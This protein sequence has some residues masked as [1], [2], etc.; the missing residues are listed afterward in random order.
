MSDASKNVQREKSVLGYL[1][2]PNATIS[3]SSESPLPDRAVCTLDGLGAALQ[4]TP[5]PPSE[6]GGSWPEVALLG[7][8]LLH[9]LCR[10][11]IAIHLCTSPV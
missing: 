3:G 11:S 10:A 2:H 8:A 4:L 5:A 7:A 6:G 9:A 1:M